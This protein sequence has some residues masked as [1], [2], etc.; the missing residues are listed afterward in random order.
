MSKGSRPGL[1][2]SI[3]GKNLELFG[4]ERK[5]E[6]LNSQGTDRGREIPAESLGETCKPRKQEMDALPTPYQRQPSQSE[7][8]NVFP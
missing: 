5:A 1:C 6:L 7:D 4:V 2:G 8:H 3:W